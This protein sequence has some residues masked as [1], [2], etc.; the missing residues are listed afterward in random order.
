[1]ISRRQG[2]GS[3]DVYEQTFWEADDEAN[4]DKALI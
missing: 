3:S 2:G 1:M 4:K